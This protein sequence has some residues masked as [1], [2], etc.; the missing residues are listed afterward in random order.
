[1]SEILSLVQMNVNPLLFFPK[2]YNNLHFSDK[3]LIASQV[4]LNPKTFEY[5]VDFP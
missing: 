5:E 3:H 4:A 1:M 2:I